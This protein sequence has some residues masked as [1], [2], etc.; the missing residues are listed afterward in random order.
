MDV[1]TR[2]AVGKDCPAARPPGISHPRCGQPLRT[3]GRP[4]ARRTGRR[5]VRGDPIQPDREGGSIWISRAKPMGLFPLVQLHRGSCPD[6]GVPR[7]DNPG[8]ARPRAQKATRRSQ[9]IGAHFPR[10][11]TEVAADIAACWAARF[12]PGFPGDFP[13]RRDSQASGRSGNGR[14]HGATATEGNRGSPTSTPRSG[15][16]M[17]SAGLGSGSTRSATADRPGCANGQLGKHCC[18]RENEPGLVG[19]PYL[20]GIMENTSYHT[21]PSRTAS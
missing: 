6:A 14:C 15:R 19:I 17:R 2:G 20:T 7:G 16:S 11:A 8:Q 18:D 1:F 9:A 3:R 21:I 5:R 4:P 13:P 12:Q 10:R